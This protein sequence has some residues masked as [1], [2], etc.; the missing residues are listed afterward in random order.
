MC[1]SKK[2]LSGSC[3]HFDMEGLNSPAR[4]THAHKV[5]SVGLSAPARNTHTHCI[6]LIRPPSLCRHT[7][8]W[9]L[10]RLRIVSSLGREE[11]MASHVS[12]PG[13]RLIALRR[14]TR[15]QKSPLAQVSTPVPNPARWPPRHQL[16]R[17]SFLL[18]L[19]R[20]TFSCA[21]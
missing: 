4:H 19:A 9:C 21:T 18:V 1:R 17:H 13:F 8:A 5:T 20:S 14:S 6:T 7:C 10:S 15:K 16:G 2:L 12:Q 3:F 11:G